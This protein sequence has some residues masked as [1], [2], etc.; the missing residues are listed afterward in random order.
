MTIT[1]PF[2]RADIGVASRLFRSLGD[3]MR[4][5]IVEILADGERRVTD[6]VQELG[7]SQANVSGH[8][9]CL[10]ECGL[11]IDRPHG[12]SV[13]YRLEHEELFDLLRS[14]EALVA[15]TGDEIA[16]CPNLAPGH[17]LR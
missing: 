7:S 3:P 6:L 15:R 17:R 14:A 4:L 10:K 9:A 16:L 11:V 12:R 8:L 2:E 5:A 13:F 1:R